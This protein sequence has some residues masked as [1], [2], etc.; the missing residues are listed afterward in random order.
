MKTWL[1]IVIVCL[2][3][4]LVWGLSFCSGVWPTF[5]MVFASFATGVTALVGVLTGFTPNK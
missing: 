2:G 1:K 3:G 4:G 5:S